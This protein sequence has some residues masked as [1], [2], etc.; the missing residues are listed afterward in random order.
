LWGGLILFITTLLLLIFADR[1]I[2]PIVSLLS[3]VGMGLFIDEVGKFLTQT[4]DYFYPPAAPIIYG[5]F[6]LTVFLY[7]RVR[8]PHADNRRQRLYAATEKILEMADHEL[9][10]DGKAALQESLQIIERQTADEETTRVADLLL[11]MVRAYQPPEEKKTSSLRTTLRAAGQRL[12]KRLGRRGHRWLLAGGL[13]L[14]HLVALL[15]LSMLVW[16]FLNP[17]QSLDVML[18]PLLTAGEISSVND[19]LW[20]ISRLWLDGA[21]GLMAILAALLIFANRDRVG[22]WLATMSLV[23]SLTAVN[24]VNFYLDQFEA[25]TLTLIQFSLL[26]VA[27]TYKKWYLAKE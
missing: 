14:V 7:L 27:Q 10:A 24:L 16:I 3:G 12:Q 21:T 25:I 22:V 9:D 4:N 6:L 11:Q 5:A 26:M 23:V 8:L 13:F 17:R 18:T 19:A 2:Y 1:R 20:L 15:E